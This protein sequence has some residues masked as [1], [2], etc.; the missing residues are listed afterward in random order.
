MKRLIALSTIAFCVLTLT[1][2][3]NSY[4]GPGRRPYADAQ[5]EDL[6]RFGADLAN[7]S[8]TNRAVACRSQLKRHRE[9]PSADTKLHLLIG[10]SLSDECGDI[11]TILD[12]VNAIPRRELRDERVQW[13]IEMQSEIL[14]RQSYT[15]RRLGAA[16]KKQK[17]SSPGAD[18]SKDEARILREKLEA[19]RSLERRMDETSDGQ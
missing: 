7:K 9:F 3:A 13:L 16:E 15:S 19:I 11:N 12:A 8:S 14:K 18:S 17:G 10:R 2:C 5:L 6:L 4:Y 1:G